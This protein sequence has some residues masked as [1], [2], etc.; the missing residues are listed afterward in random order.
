MVPLPAVLLSL[1]L[2][3]LPP[4]LLGP[5][6]T[7]RSGNK[8]RT[9]VTTNT[10]VDLRCVGTYGAYQTVKTARRLLSDGASRSWSFSE[11][12]FG[13]AGPTS[14]PRHSTVHSHFPSREEKERGTGRRREEWW[15]GHEVQRRE[16]WREEWRVENKDMWEKAEGGHVKYWV[17]VSPRQTSNFQVLKLVC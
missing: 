5:N 14:P 10:C 16:G 17:S 11:I 9:C 7:K 2:F 8:G 13:R 15:K 4:S 3:V 1:C 6:I 12:E